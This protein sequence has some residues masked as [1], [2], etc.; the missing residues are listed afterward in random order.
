MCTVLGGGYLGN[1]LFLSSFTHAHKQTEP[2][3][4]AGWR[5]S[6]NVDG[7]DVLQNAFGMRFSHP[8]S[9]TDGNL[10]RTTT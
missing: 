8:G 10:Q 2:A 7:L 9:S 1:V 5:Q 6:W 4:A 3:V